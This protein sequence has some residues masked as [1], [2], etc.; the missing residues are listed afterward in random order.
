[1]KY[2]IGDKVKLKVGSPLYKSSASVLPASYVKS[3]KVTYIT[4]VASGTKHPY[5]TTGDLGWMNE[6]DISYYEEPK[7][8]YEVDIEVIDKDELIA[9]IYDHPDKVIIMDSK[10]LKDVIDKQS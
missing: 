9:Y 6:S 7:D 8:K 4:R 10:Q 3:E 1:M 2:K 5:N